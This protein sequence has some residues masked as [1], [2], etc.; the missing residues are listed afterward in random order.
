MKKILPAL[1]ALFLV[2]C[3]IESKPFYRL[4][5][6]NDSEHK[7][8][9]VAN[10]R[11]FIGE[12]LS[13]SIVIESKNYVE[14]EWYVSDILTLKPL[15]IYYD[16]IIKDTLDKKNDRWIG[17]PKNYEYEMEKEGFYVG[18]Y[19]FTEEDYQRA[20]EKHVPKQ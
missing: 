9:I 16:I 18:T 10:P 1:L 19:T 2:G 15:I 12:G 6:N 3:E 14:S 4:K 17:S 13:D 7:I 5:I 8:A 20:L 11:G